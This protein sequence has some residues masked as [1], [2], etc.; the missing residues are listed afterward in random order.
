[1]SFV[2]A[3]LAVAAKDLR[4][5]A[6]ARE[7]VYAMTFFSALVVL[8]F[9]FAFTREG[10]ADGNAVAGVLWIAVAFSGTLGLGR[11]MDRE[12]EGNTMRALLLA[13]ID[14]SAIY[15]GKLLGITAFMLLAEA[16]AV[17]IAALLFSSTGTSLL[18][19]A[20]P[21]ALLLGLGTVGYA[22]V[23]SLFAAMLARARARDV[24][25]GILLY[26]VVLPVLI[27]GTRGTQALLAYPSPEWSEVWLW[28]R[29]IVLFD[30]VFVTLALWVY[31]P[32]VAVE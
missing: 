15:V 21:L 17:P 14:R 20:A 5:E 9:A 6:R 4:I 29:I 10:I 23:G 25:L 22:A 11:A 7:I 16:V 1:V 8:L 2:R 3:A 12:R 28:T 30:L 19:H 26:P 27:A 31:E 13:P 24:L 32:L 18:S